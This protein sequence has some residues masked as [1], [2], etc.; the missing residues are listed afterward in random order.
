MYEDLGIY[1]LLAFFVFKNKNE[2][3]FLGF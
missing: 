2:F 1:S 3:M